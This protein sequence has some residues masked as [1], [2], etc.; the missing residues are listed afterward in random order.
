[1]SARRWASRGGGGAGIPIKTNLALL[2]EDPPHIVV[3]T[4]GR[5]KDLAGRPDGLKLNKVKFFIL[6]E[7]DKMLEAAGTFR[8]LAPSLV[9]GSARVCVRGCAPACALAGVTTVCGGTCADMR[10]DVQKIFIQTPVD[11]QVMMFS[12]TLSPEVRTV[13]RKFMSDVRAVDPPPALPTL[14]S[15]C[16]TVVVNPLPSPLVRVAAAAHSD[17]LSPPQPMEIHVDQQRKLTLHGLVQ[18]YVK[19]KPEQKNRKLTDL[20]DSLEFNQVIIFVSKVVRAEELNRLLQECSFPST[21]VHA[22]IKDQAERCVT[23]VVPVRRDSVARSLAVPCV[24]PAA[25]FW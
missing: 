19:L 23:R 11:K 8:V 7:C 2:K 15:V 17:V 14:A 25:C 10:A 16:S 24:C 12:A 1:V 13:C 21:T 18:Y 6:D 3:G 20:L 9:C 4:P 5:I 22:G